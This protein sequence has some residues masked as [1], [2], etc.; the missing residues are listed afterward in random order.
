MIDK[1]EI[2]TK[3][4]K[5]FGQCDDGTGS[6]LAAWTYIYI[7]STILQINP[8]LAILLL[9]PKGDNHYLPQQV[10]NLLNNNEKNTN[11]LQ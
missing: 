9:L 5:Q 1:H 8:P 10:L 3:F 7:I 6:E 2:L 11:Y 4:L